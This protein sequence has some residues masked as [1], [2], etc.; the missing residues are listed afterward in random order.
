[1]NKLTEKEIESI[2]KSASFNELTK[3]ALEVILRLPQPLGQISG[4]IST[5]GKG[6]S[7]ENLKEFRDLMVYLKERNFDVFDQIPFERTIRKLKDIWHREMNDNNYCMPI[8]EEFYR[9]IITSGYIKHFFFLPDW[10]TSYGARWEHEECLKHG[11]KVI[12]LSPNWREDG[13]FLNEFQNR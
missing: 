12:Y 5:G 13:N 1:M 6:N 2:H 3:V 7:E 10:R 4:P 11:L 8:L 9:P